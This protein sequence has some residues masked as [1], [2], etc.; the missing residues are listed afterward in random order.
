MN[1]NHQI[2]RRVLNVLHD[3]LTARD[4]VRLT[5]LDAHA[6][7]LGLQRLV[8]AGKVSR[9]VRRRFMGKYVWTPVVAREAVFTSKEVR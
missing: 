2:E 4:I 6:V 1:R 8:R 5:A 7:R 3:A 9:E